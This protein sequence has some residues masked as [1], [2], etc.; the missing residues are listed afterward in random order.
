MFVMLML[1]LELNLEVIQRHHGLVLRLSELDL[2]HDPEAH[3]LLLLLPSLQGL[4]VEG[5]HTD[6]ELDEPGPNVP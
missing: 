3:L 6:L 2:H 5:R 4:C 1:L